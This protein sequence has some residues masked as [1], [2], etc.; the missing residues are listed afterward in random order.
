MLL[1]V[2]EMDVSKVSRRRKDYDFFFILISFLR[3]ET[4]EQAKGT[5][6]TQDLANIV[7]LYDYEII[8]HVQCATEGTSE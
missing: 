4:I 7:P 5:P 3:V 2:K 8:T 6:V 1:K